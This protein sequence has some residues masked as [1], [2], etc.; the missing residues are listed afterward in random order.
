MSAVAL[1]A[2]VAENGVIGRGG[3]MPWHL[4]ADLAHF[5]RITMGKPIVMGRRTFEA[6]GRALPGR[7]NI[8]VT[9]AAEFS[10]P[11]VER[12]ASPEEALALAG[13]AAEVMVIGGAELYRAALPLARR[14]YLTRVH[15][16]V[17]G[18]T[19]FPELDDREWRELAREKRAADEK[20]ACA[21]TFLTLERKQAE[22]N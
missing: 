1:V 11:G 17:A 15:A 19:F 4:P 8:V 5:K 22:S 14:I 20:N 12:A 21:L 6:I 3:V 16:E 18:D 10:A 13:D 2:A 9:R 7:R